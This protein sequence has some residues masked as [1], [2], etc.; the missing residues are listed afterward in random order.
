MSFLKKITASHGG[1]E[2]KAIVE[3][4]LSSI[5]SSIESTRGNF[6]LEKI[7]SS[8]GKEL[9]KIGISTFFSLYDARQKIITIKYFFVEKTDIYL[10][11][12]IFDDGFIPKKIPLDKLIKYKLIIEKK[13]AVFCENR[14]KELA[15][16]FPLSKK[17][18]HL[19]VRLPQLPLYVRDISNRFYQKQFLRYPFLLLFQQQ[20]SQQL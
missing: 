13:Q 18:I 10:I 6:D 3:K 12:K 11:N 14:L 9:L 1:G 17:L 8:I 2:N 15:K 20:V 5:Q 16:N 19:H 7:Y 4:T